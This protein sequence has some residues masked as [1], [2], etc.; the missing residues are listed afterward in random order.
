MAFPTNK[1]HGLELRLTRIVEGRHHESVGEA[2]TTRSEA[3]VKPP[4]PQCAP[5][6]KIMC[7]SLPASVPLAI[8]GIFWRVAQIMKT[9]DI[10]AAETA[11]RAINCAALE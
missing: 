6:N 8:E 5:P 9:M 11:Y 4:T 7:T 1:D 2:K 3:T 10:S